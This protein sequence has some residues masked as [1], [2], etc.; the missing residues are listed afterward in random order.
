MDIDPHIATVVIDYMCCVFSLYA[1]QR[2][3]MVLEG[4]CLRDTLTYVRRGGLILMMQVALY[5]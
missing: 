2:K 3:K 1:G 5:A 4:L